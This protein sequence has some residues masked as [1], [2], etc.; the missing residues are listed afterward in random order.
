MI[1]AFAFLIFYLTHIKMSIL[2]KNQKALVLGLGETGWSCVRWLL[3]QGAQVAVADTRQAPPFLTHAQKMFPTLP[4]HLGEWTPALFQ[5]IDLIVVSPGVAIAH[6]LIQEAQQRQVAVIGDI[7]LFAWAVRPEAK[8][9]AI[10]GSN[11]KSTVTEMCGACCRHAGLKTVVAGNIGLPILDALAVAE[12]QEYADVFVLELSSF[13]LE[14]TYTLNAHAA[15]VLNV[16]QDH[17]D[18]YENFAHYAQTKARIFTGEGV[19]IL[20]KNDPECVKMA[21]PGR[22]VQYFDRDHLSDELKTAFQQLK[23]AGKHNVENALA[24]LLLCQ[25]IG[26]KKQ[27]VL[28]ALCAFKGLPHRVEFVDEIQH[29]R[30]YDD[31][32]GT[33]VGATVAALTGFEVPIVLIL[34]GDGKGQDFSVMREAVLKHARAVILIGKDAPIIE[35][36]L[37]NQ[38]QVPRYQAQSMHEAVQISFAQAKPQDIVLLSPACASFDMFTGYAHRA[39]VFIEA[40]EQLKQSFL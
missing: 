13:Q 29:V 5:E 4:I 11:G 20:N 19:Q 12:D 39:Q 31:S 2:L 18:R 23:V 16:T 36:A 22:T 6:P 9:I 3:R 27:A 32:K 24:T 35:A 17:L 7:E 8:V 34:G 28:D 15:T 14:T 26:L 38:D 10:T 1:L 33:N 37:G 21:L 40:V 25:N 30:F